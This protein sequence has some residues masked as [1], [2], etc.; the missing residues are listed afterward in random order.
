MVVTM[1]THFTLTARKAGQLLG[2]S[3]TAQMERSVL[4]I[5][6][7]IMVST[8]LRFLA[9]SL[10]HPPRKSG[11]EGKND[12]LKTQST[13]MQRKNE[14]VGTRCGWICLVFVHLALCSFDIYSSDIYSYLINSAFF[15]IQEFLLSPI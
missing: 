5:I 10:Q 15:F 2:V 14:C 9:L 11:L 8:I 3:L 7:D 4:K 1:G 6:L 13:N 12:C